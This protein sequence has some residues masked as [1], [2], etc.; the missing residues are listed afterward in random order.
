MSLSLP[1][2]VAGNVAKGPG[3]IEA[4]ADRIQGEK[5]ADHDQGG[6]QTVFDS[7]DARGIPDKPRKKY[8]HRQAPLGV[9]SCPAS[10]QKF[11]RT[12]I[13]HWIF[14]TAARH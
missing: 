8:H 9:P 1:S 12:L 13:T 2:Q 6:N 14:Q 5:G 7:G 10:D 4:E 11:D 3:E